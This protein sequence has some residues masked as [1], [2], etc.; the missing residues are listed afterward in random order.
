M[1]RLCGFE[2]VWKGGRSFKTA[3]R[4]IACTCHIASTLSCDSCRSLTLLL[5]PT[6]AICILSTNCVKTQ[7]PIDLGELLEFL[8]TLSKLSKSH[9]PAK[10][11]K[12]SNPTATPAKPPPSLKKE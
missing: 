3:T 2:S 9:Q 5:F 10:M 7:R 6:T 4:K 8:F 12:S 1:L 11:V